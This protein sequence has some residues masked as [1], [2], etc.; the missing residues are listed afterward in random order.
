MLN[1]KIKSLNQNKT[2]RNSNNSDLIFVL[3]DPVE[4]WKQIKYYKLMA[5]KDLYKGHGLEN[6]VLYYLK[7]TDP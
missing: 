2:Y 3:R 6:L 4:S 5:Q 7:R 1:N